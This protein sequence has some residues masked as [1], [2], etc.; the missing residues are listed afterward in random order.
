MTATAT[1]TQR[2]SPQRLASLEWVT[3]AGL[4]GCALAF[5]WLDLQAGG[6]ILP[7]I[8]L[9]LCL[10]ISAGIVALGRRWTPLAGV[11]MGSGTIIGGFSQ[12]YTAYH[13]THPAEWGGFA[14]TLLSLACAL[15]AFA[16]GLAATIQNYRSVQRHTPRWLALA[17]TGLAGLVIGALIV[18]AIPPASTTPASAGNEPAVHLGVTTFVPNAIRIPKGAKLRIVEDNSILH[19]LA[20][21]AWKG[22]TPAPEQEPGAP[23]VENVMVNGNSAEI[24]PFTTPGVFHIYCTLHP[25][26]DLIVLVE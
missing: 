26:M 25:G 24:G 6:F 20:N 10:A 16:G 13:L 22:N 19:I 9:I 18:A 7:L 15:V 12:P 23:L 14:A 17:L 21:G 2:R 3:L 11:I 1:N 8:T 5:L 4:L